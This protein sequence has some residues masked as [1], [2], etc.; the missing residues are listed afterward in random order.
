MMAKA[1]TAILA[2]WMVATA[3]AGAA[4]AHEGAVGQV[5][6]CSRVERNGARTLCHEIVVSA[7]REAVWAL[8][9]TS[10]GLS[11]W[12]APYVAL[13]LRIGGLWEASYRVGAHA[14]DAANIRNRVLSYAPG[15]MLSIQVERAPPGFPH[16]DLVAGTWSVIELQDE[17]SGATR[18]RVSGMGY[19]AGDGFDELYAFFERGNAWTLE[20]LQARVLNGPT[21]WSV[22]S[23][24]A[25][26]R[27]Q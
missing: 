27:G 22:V 14:G 21:D 15:R 8:F 24:P 6:S 26:E 20:Q 1:A 12:I 3:A 5:R 17:G 11:T 13:D 18:V 7:P 23:A 10:E 9:S 4:A 16:A 2:L 19:G 25:S